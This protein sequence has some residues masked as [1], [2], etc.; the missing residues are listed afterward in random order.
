[1]KTKHYMFVVGSFV[2][3]HP[4]G[5]FLLVYSMV[6]HLVFNIKP[7]YFLNNI[8]QVAETLTVK[9]FY[10]VHHCHCG[11]QISIYE[12]HVPQQAVKFMYIKMQIYMQ[13]QYISRFK[14][15]AKSLSN[16]CTR[17]LVL[18]KKI[19]KLETNNLLAYCLIQH[20]LSSV[21]W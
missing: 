3:F 4:C 18:G 1:M 6:K 8:Q 2:Y 20:T 12:L 5:K 19:L 10:L 11:Y 16:M 7:C 15:Q 9:F 17:M 21:C 13:W 14:S